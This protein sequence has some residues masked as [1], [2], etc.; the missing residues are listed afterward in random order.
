MKNFYD[1]M[2]DNG[3]K[4]PEGNISGAWFYDNDIP[5]IVMCNCCG[6]TMAS[7]SAWI[8]DEGHTY[9]ESCADVKEEN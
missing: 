9:C 7:P 2:K 8:D 6:M 1:Y 5:M 4:V 3:I